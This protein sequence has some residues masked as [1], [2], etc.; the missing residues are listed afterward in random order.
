[1]G[2]KDDLIH[3]LLLRCGCIIQILLSLYV[4]GRASVCK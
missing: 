2:I 4:G 1:M 3:T